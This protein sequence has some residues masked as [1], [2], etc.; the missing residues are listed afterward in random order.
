MPSRGCGLQHGRGPERGEA[1]RWEVAG[2]EGVL[3]WSTVER[4]REVLAVNEERDVMFWLEYLL[5][6]GSGGGDGEFWNDRKAGTGRCG[7][8]E[9]GA[10]IFSFSTATTSLI[11]IMLGCLLAAEWRGDISTIWERALLGAE[12]DNRV[13][14]WRGE[15]AREK[16]TYL[17]LWR[18][19]RDAPACT[20]FIRASS[21]SSLPLMIEGKL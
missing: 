8:I 11:L 18:L 15:K 4:D 2:T 10:K 9:G 12:A 13:D 20:E 21:A 17:G 6:E 14:W 5:T 16:F 3:D 1:G 19:S 7:S